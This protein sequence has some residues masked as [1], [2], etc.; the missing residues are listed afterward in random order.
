RP[1]RCDIC[2]NTFRRNEHLSRHLRTHTGE[3]PF[4]CEELGCGRKFSRSDELNRH[5]KVH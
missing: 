2:S 3:K 5:S 4:V 1:Y